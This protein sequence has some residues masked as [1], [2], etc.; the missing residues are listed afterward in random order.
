[1]AQALETWGWDDQWEALLS[2]SDQGQPAR[3]TAH[4]RDRWILQTVDGPHGARVT[5]PVPG[6]RMPATGDWVIAE[7]GP[8]PSD[9]W[10]IND[11]LTRRSALT[12][13]SAGDRQTEQVLAA[14][15]DRLWI[16]HGLDARPNL[17]RLERYLAVG[18]ESGASPEVVLTKSD[19]AAHLEESVGAA[20]E[21]AFGVPVWVVSVSDPKA[22]VG[23]RGS[24][25]HG[26]TVALVGPS[27]V[28]KSTLINLM[29]EAEVARTAEVRAGDRKGRHTTTMRELVRIHNGALLLDTPGLRELRVLT[30]DKG[31]GGAFPEIED[32]AARCRFRDC[33]HGTEPG[34]AVLLAVEEG[35]LASDRLT[36]FRKLMAEAAFERR[37]ADPRLMAE[38]VA[39]HKTAMKTLK[40]HLKHQRPRDHGST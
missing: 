35:R 8:Y 33:Q 31:L 37:R 4:H 19:L 15:V 3:V 13:G 36:S 20:Q 38:V 29:A 34:C 16:V 17:R 18:W 28:G 14:N 2:D 21:I 1:M 26:S 22:L 30:L 23:L 27:G 5:G 11:V 25:E 6:D 9:P 39:E 40:Q 10:T 24:L 7:P 12:R 32:L